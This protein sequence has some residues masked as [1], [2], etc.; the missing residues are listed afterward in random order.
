MKQAQYTKHFP[1]KYNDHTN[2]D[3]NRFP[4]YGRR[5]T[6]IEV[7]KNGSKLDNRNLLV[8]FDEHINVETCNY[9]K[10]VKYLFKYVHKGSDRAITIVE[11]NEL[12]TDSDEIK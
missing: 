4:I 10:S 12:T 6:Y 3:T 5:R 2:F 11:N 1:N 9:S 8:L 7:M